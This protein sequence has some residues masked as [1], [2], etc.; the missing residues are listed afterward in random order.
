MPE[1]EESPLT[2]PAGHTVTHPHTS[3]HHRLPAGRAL[4]TSAPEVARGGS[5]SR[6]RQ[7]DSTG[8]Q[9][10][11][12]SPGPGLPILQGWSQRPEVGKGPQSRM[13][14]APGTSGD[15]HSL[16]ESLPEP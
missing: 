5:H 2:G 15:M 6:Y 12:L 4:K 9:L 11:S 16:S 3:T 7:G 14:D 8:A 13:M 1:R 10:C